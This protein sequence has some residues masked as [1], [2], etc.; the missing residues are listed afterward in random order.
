M[1]TIAMPETLKRPRLEFLD[2]VRGLAAF[3][4]MFEHAGYRFL[5]HYRYFSHVIIS[6]GKFG[7]AAFF[8]V[9]GF[10]IPLS[11]DRTLRLDTFL[12]PPTLSPLPSLLVQSCR[13]DLPLLVRF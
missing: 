13:R 2:G 11:L 8:L 9:S 6:F 5:P 3:F 1:A 12:D 10:V 7:V 4:V